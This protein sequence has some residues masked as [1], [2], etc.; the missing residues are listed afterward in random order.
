MRHYDD[1]IKD[2]LKWLSDTLGKPEY[3]PEI[4]LD[5][6]ENEINIKKAKLWK[7]ILDLCYKK[8]E[9]IYW[10]KKFILGNMTYAGYPEPIRFN[11]LWWKWA[12]LC[13][14]GDHLV[15]KC[16]RQHGKSTF[17]TVIMPL[18]RAC[19]FEH[20]NV[21]IASASE[22]Q[23]IQL[24]SHIVRLIEN[25][26]FLFSKKP[27]TGKWS[28]TD[29]EYNGGNI[30]ARGVG[31]EVRGG[32]YDYIVC[33]DILRSDNK[34][35]DNDIENYIDEELEPMILVR[36]G[37]MVIVGT[38][39]SE[40]DIFG[41]ISDRIDNGSTWI[42]N[43]YPAILD[44]ENKEL[45]C[46][47]R[48]TWEQLMA[49][50]ERQGRLKFEKEFMCSSNTLVV[51]GN[52][53]KPIYNIKKG[54]RVKTLDGLYYEVV[55]T[56]NRKYEGDMY[57][58]KTRLSNHIL[59]FTPEHPFYIYD[60]IKYLWKEAKNL[61]TGEYMVYPIGYTHD[62]AGLYISNYLTSGY[63]FSINNGKKMLI[64]HNNTI[65]KPYK[66]ELLYRDSE[67]G[68]TV[69]ELSKKYGIK[70]NTIYNI[71]K[72]KNKKYKK[73]I[74]D[75]IKIDNDLMRLFGYYLSEGCS[76]TT[77]SFSFHKNEINLQQDV[78]KILKDKFNLRA[79]RFINKNV[80]QVYVCNK[81]LCNFFSNFLGKGAKNKYIP[82]LLIHGT[83]PEKLQHLLDAY[84]AGDGSKIKNG[85]KFTTISPRLIEN[86][87]E[88]SLI[89]GKPCSYS[90]YNT[91]K[92]SIIEGRIINQNDIYVGQIFD[93][94]HRKY[95]FL[96]NGYL[97]SRISR[98]E[99]KHV[100]TKVYNLEIGTLCPDVILIDNKHETYCTPSGIV[101]NCRTYSSGSQLFPP[102]I[103]KAAMDKGKLW[104]LYSKINYSEKDKVRYY[105]GVDCARAGT[106]GGD[107]TV[108]TVIAYDPKTQEKRLVWIWR[109][110]GLKISEQ[111]E[112]I[113]EMSR[114]FENPVVLVEK[115]NIGQEFIDM[116][117][118][119]FNVN[120]E[121][122]TTTKG[123]K[124]EDLIR[125]LVTAFEN[126]KII[127]PNK[128]E[129]SREV[130][131]EL[132]RELDR[133][134]VE[135]THAGNERYKGSGH[136]HD[137]MVISL[138]LANRCSQSYGYKPFLVTGQNRKSSSLER[139]VATGDVR[140]VMRL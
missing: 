104:S 102:E 47:D 56:M 132:N 49:V 29:I 135:T 116:L 8:T 94:L 118:D 63:A 5:G 108:V 53:Y 119:N 30:V 1:I 106:A 86:I 22:D 137:D 43:T 41:V 113:A 121:D 73:S 35:S 18:Y 42:L 11:S 122:F 111:V 3:L 99:K 26:E 74:P 12:K 71:L 45:L 67:R 77:L 51:T 62:T 9:G 90:H 46:P 37:Q 59:D 15:I 126:E 28:T 134:V 139:F 84:L 136:T 70:Q 21:L 89:C 27:K 107:Y 72:N 38:P 60:G 16:S 110:K 87:R 39:K 23:G 14:E 128:D 129:Y 123:N 32:T 117:V 112:K 52:G 92:K 10:F 7:Q 103:R 98:I 95:G 17:W 13:N 131:Q 100:D 64:K 4:Y 65:L 24:M 55:N 82:G 101:H 2:Y 19:L 133:F 31:S 81:L 93:K 78:I 138:A 85:W 48:F 40:S 91:K 140:E 88:I 66:L 44:W 125:Y 50:R 120:V 33:D 54:E 68:I 124:Y 36:R 127:L 80:C 109:K 114:A 96:E 105:M 20:Y 115:N 6:E 58:I 79:K 75:N 34:L 130:I 76:S 83:S 25:N 97:H 57:F 69:K 61:K